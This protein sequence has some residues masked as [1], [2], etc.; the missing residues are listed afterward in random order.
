MIFQ[1][2]WQQILAGDKVQT[3][4][5][6]QEG[7]E[8]DLSI[9]MKGYCSMV[10]MVAYSEMGATSGK[11]AIPTPPI[12]LTANGKQRRLTASRLAAPLLLRVVWVVVRVL[13]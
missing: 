11:S 2:T 3:R 12:T 5:L 4:R 8:A 10:G 13:R 9:A 7:D 1:H 6:V